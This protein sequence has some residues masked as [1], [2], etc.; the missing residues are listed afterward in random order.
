MNFNFKTLDKVYGP[1]ILSSALLQEEI[2]EMKTWQ[3][4]ILMAVV[5][6]VT[7]LFLGGDFPNIA[8]VD[9]FLRLAAGGAL[10]AFTGF[11]VGV[12]H[13]LSRDNKSPK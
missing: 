1:A 4:A 12:P 8:I 2:N 5:V 3:I 11:L 7:V 13:F 9:V 10:G 6:A